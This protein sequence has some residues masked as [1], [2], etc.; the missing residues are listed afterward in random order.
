MALDQ[1]Q[2][3]QKWCFSSLGEIANSDTEFDRHL[4]EDFCDNG[5]DAPL[6]EHFQQGQQHEIGYE[7]AECQR[8]SQLV[9]TR[10]GRCNYCYQLFHRLRDREGRL[11]CPKLRSIVCCC[12]GATGDNAHTLKFC[13]ER[14]KS[15]TK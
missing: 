7:I 6:E 4:R 14:K 9:K 12:C 8:L 3:D 2:D 11:T 15:N 5:I 1:Q 10:K 13:P